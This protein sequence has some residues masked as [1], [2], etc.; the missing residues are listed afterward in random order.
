MDKLA[1]KTKGGPQ[2]KRYMK[3]SF[4]RGSA[5]LQNGKWTIRYLVRDPNSPKGWRHKRETLPGC[6]SEKQARHVLSQR[7][8]AVNTLNNNL[9]SVV[10]VITLDEF[11]GRRILKPHR[12]Q[13]RPP[14]A[15]TRCIGITS[16]HDTAANGW[17]RLP[18]RP[19]GILRCFA[20]EEM[21]PKYALNSTEC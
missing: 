9:R 3:S 6:K 21:A 20:D 7:L 15:M 14:T 4:Q 12:L 16:N 5:R 8:T 11:G 17:S 13:T 18:H 1:L 19:D 2:E 10:R